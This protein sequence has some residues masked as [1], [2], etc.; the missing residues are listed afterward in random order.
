MNAGATRLPRNARRSIAPSPPHAIAC[1]LSRPLSISQVR[2]L[3]ADATSD[4]PL[5][6]SPSFIVSGPMTDAVTFLDEYRAS[7]A[8]AD[9]AEAGARSSG[10][11]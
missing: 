1:C 11:G 9:G 8:S 6:R 7:R 4:C 3:P 10:N 5:D 2:A